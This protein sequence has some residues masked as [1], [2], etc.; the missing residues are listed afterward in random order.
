MKPLSKKFHSLCCALALAFLTV[1]PAAAQAMN[2]Y[3]VTAERGQ[4]EV[5]LSLQGSPIKLNIRLDEGAQGR[6]G[7]S[8]ARTPPLP[9]SY[10]IPESAA[11]E[12]PVST[13]AGMGGTADL[14]FTD[15]E[16]RESAIVS[17]HDAAVAG[18]ARDAARPPADDVFAEAP[19]PIL[20]RQRAEP[21]KA[22]RS[23]AWLWVHTGVAVQVAGNVADWA[24][25]WKQP[26]G[27]QW[28]AQSGG[29]YA[30]KFYSSA[31]VRKA[32]LSAGLA[33]VSYAVAW[34]WPRARKYVGIF[35]M[36]VGVGFGA[37]AVSNVIRNPSLQP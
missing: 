32:A 35:N 7:V 36:T 16:R 19:E 9:D 24:T 17:P 11:Y 21:G 8:D 31:T 33:V 4:P 27:N 14:V 15:G 20:I 25:S 18:A 13:L 26:E 5:S 12:I 10:P 37:A 1:I 6:L 22:P 3:P 29:P 34:K 28:L 2:A 23:A 30:G